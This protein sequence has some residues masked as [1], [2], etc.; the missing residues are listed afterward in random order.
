MTH[1]TLDLMQ[2]HLKKTG[3]QVRER[4]LSFHS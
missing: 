2:E 1:K 3:G 4:N